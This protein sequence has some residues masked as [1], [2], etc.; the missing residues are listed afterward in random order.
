MVRIMDGGRTD[1]G[2]VEVI[3]NATAGFPYCCTTVFLLAF[4]YM[5]AL[6]LWGLDSE[7]RRNGGTYRRTRRLE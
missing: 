4:V 1:G 6:R 3:E 7:K 5:V 2:E